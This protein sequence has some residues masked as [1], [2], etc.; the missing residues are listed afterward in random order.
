[1]VEAED[2]AI[3]IT[4]SSTGISFRV[5]GSEGGRVV[6]D[7]LPVE[8]LQRRADIEKFEEEGEEGINVDDVE[9]FVASEVLPLIAIGGDGFS[10]VRI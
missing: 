9:T 4:L 2:I 8:G 1:M 3:E 6:E 7:F 10:L 5:G